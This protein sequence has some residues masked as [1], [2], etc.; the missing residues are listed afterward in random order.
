MPLWDE[1]RIIA[2]SGLESLKAKPGPG[3]SELLYKL[4]LA[5]RRFDAKDI[6]WKLCPTINA[7]RRMGSPE[8][9]AA[10]FFEKDPRQRDRLAGELV[11]LN[12][13][14]KIL[15]E[16]TWA[17]AEPA[18]YKSLAEYDE[19]L[20]LVYG[21]EINKGVAGLMAQRIARRFNVPAMAVSFNGDICTGSLR[22]AR[23]YNIG[24]LLE[25]CADL[26]IDSGGHEFAGGFTMEKAN[27][28]S[29]LERLKTAA[30]SIEFIGGADEEIVS[31][32]AE[33]PPNYLSP[34]IFNL[35]DRFEPY[36]KGNEPLVFMAK[37]IT[38]TK[39]SYIGSE[40]Q[41]LKME[42]DCGKHKW[43][44]LYWQAADRVLNKEFGVNDRVDVV[45]T[46]SR[47]YYKGSE[48][49]QMMITDVRKSE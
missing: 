23:G 9:A 28:D 8:K 5:G 40:S 34:D 18:A 14:R 32:D 4:D 35:I 20:A 36:G 6:S 38:I 10:L 46:L 31:I 29:L 22:S 43:P 27:W 48:T 1:N 7:A 15:E 33:L 45:F 3:L 24:A 16:E 47:D 25:Q 49:P 37:K 30:C 26:F 39:I 19:K 21:E 12:E 17:V 44:A 2:R 42:L 11:A 41:H 13:D